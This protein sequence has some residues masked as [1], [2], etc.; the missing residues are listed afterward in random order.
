MFYPNSLGLDGGNYSFWYIYPLS[1]IFGF[2]FISILQERGIYSSYGVSKLMIILFILGLTYYFLY[3]FSIELRQALD[4]KILSIELPSFIKVNHFTFL[5]SLIALFFSFVISFVF[6]KT[7][8]EIT[9]SWLLLYLLIPALFFQEKTYFLIFSI[10]GTFLIFISVLQDTYKMAYLDTLTSIPSRRALEED[11]LKLGSKYALAMVDIDFFKKF[12]DTYGH[13]VGDDV[14]K[15]IAKQLQEVQGRAKAYRYG[16]EEFTILFSN[17]S[18][19]EAYMFLEEIREKIAKRGFMLR[20]KD[21]PE[22]PPAKNKKTKKAKSIN[23]SVSIGVASSS[24]ELKGPMDVMKK[25]DLALY[26]AKEKGRNC[27]IKA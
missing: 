25:A 17:K 13:D 16:G 5:I 19:D 11:F 22:S 18:A 1:V 21:R 23:L 20:D 2:L 10:L 24:K 6:F 12:N 9:P 3:T 4:L 27:T 14:L 15:I 7:Q 8:S 26:K